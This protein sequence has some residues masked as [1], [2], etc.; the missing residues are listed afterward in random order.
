MTK[1][2][3]ISPGSPP[4]LKL[5]A[6]AKEINEL[7][8][9]ITISVQRV[10]EGAC[11]AVSNAVLAGR[12]ILAAREMLPHGQ[13]LDWLA[14]HCPSVSRATATRYMTLAK[15]PRVIEGASSIRHALALISGDDNEH[16]EKKAKAEW[17][18]YLEG[19][20]R[21][22]KW[23]GFVAK[24]PVHEWPDAG[25]VELKAKL[26]PIARD[27]WPEKFGG[28]ESRQPEG[29]TVDV[30]SNVEGS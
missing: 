15:N 24:H 20:R 26:E 28:T 18:A 21:A 14:A 1:A 22:S 13:F 5:R 7:Q 29:R 19:V 4:A 17:P 8:S 30:G 2:Q 6:L 11:I 25:K 23:A 12:S 9:A 16:D 27:L 3:L 10:E